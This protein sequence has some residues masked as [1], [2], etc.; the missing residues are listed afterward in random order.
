[1]PA[2]LRSAAAAP[3]E[4][5][6]TAAGEAA[7]GEAAAGEAVKPELVWGFNEY[8]PFKYK[9]AG[10]YHGI[11]VRLMQEVAEQLGV[12]LRIEECPLNRCLQMMRT[13]AIDV[14]TS[15]GHRGDRNSYIDFVQPPYNGNNTKGV[16][17]RKDSA[18][19]IERYED[20][21]RYKIGVKIG[22]TYFPRFDADTKIKKDAVSD[23]E[24]N[25]RK[26][27]A[28]RIDAVLN[29]E[30]QFEYLAIR[31]G[32]D[33]KFVKTTL[34]VEAGEDFIGISKRSLFVKRRA[35]FDKIVAG[36]V[37]TKR[38]E[39]IRKDFFEKVRQGVLTKDRN[40]LAPAPAVEAGGGEEA[41]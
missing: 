26:L 36:L 18:V 16:Y 39:T 3:D 14:M 19:K 8:A 1:M 32:L 27:A 2:A 13:G 41:P 22:A 35:E 37:R 30:I 25:L 33:G 11:D 10:R 5:A 28:G 31:L 24:L 23:V 7:A 4:P 15:V 21:Y 12:S 20:L 38:V 6:K 40:G 17:I 29:T 9:E 34:A